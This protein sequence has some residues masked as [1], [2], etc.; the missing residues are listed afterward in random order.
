M[1]LST[2][3][4]SKG[5]RSRPIGTIVAGLAAALVVASGPVNA[6]AQRATVRVPDGLS[7]ARCELTFQPAAALVTPS[8]TTDG[9]PIAVRA[10][11]QGR[12]WVFRRGD[13][14]ALFDGNGKFLRTLGRRG[15][16][17]GEFLMAYDLLVA[18]N[19]TIV[20]MDVSGA[21]AT[22]YLSSLT[23]VR[24]VTL[25]NQMLDPIVISWPN[26][27][28]SGGTLPTPDGIGRQLHRI[29]FAGRE[30]R[31]LKSFGPDE[32][33]VGPDASYLAYQFPAPVRNG[34]FWS[35]AFA[36]FDMFQ[37]KTDGTLIRALQRRPAWFSKPS[38]M[39]YNWK[40]EPPPPHIAAIHEDSAGLIWVFVRVAARTW[41][42]AW[43]GVPESVREVPG[44]LIQ[45]DKLYATTV[46]VINPGT[47][48]VVARKTFDRYVISALSDR[49]AA[50]YEVDDAGMARIV[51]GRL[52][53]SGR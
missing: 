12:F 23:P 21:R 51:V 28:V 31:V 10:D 19:D 4:S 33:E 8:D 22:V 17:P 14:P 1:K 30:G 9:F 41:R 13:V 35:I 11:R 7:C 20:V 53:L 42:E 18:G 29:S 46:E 37:W 49:R 26:S 39:D 44:R 2:S 36:S 50:F 52:L 27:I 45:S 25:P 6:G 15:R 38:P 40:T 32:G 5:T 43:P 16:G 34:A 48:R 3:K 24:Y 47:R